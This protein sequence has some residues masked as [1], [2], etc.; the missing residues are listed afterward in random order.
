MGLDPRKKPC[1]CADSAT[2]PGATAGAAR[3]ATGGP[4]LPVTRAAGPEAGGPILLTCDGVEV[5]QAIQDMP[6]SVALVAEKRTIARV[7]LSTGG[8]APV[9]VNGVLRVR[10]VG[11]IGLG[12]AVRALAPVTLDPALT[13]NLRAK[14]ENETRSLNFILPRQVLKAGQWEVRLSSLF[15]PVPHKVIAVPAGAKRTVTFVASP[16]L[17]VRI[18]GIRYRSG[19]QTV[20]P[21]ALDFTLIQSWLGRAYPVASVDW[22]QVT[23]DG[24]DPWPFDAPAMNAFVRGLRAIDVAGGVDGRTHYYGLVADNGGSNFMR[25]LASGI[26]AT[27]DP[28]TVASGPCGGSDFGWDHDGSYGDWYTGHELGHTFGR[29]HAEF[30]GAGGGAAYPFP[31]GQLSGPDGAFVGFDVGDIGN[32]LPPRALPGTTSHDLMS[33]CDNQWVSSFTYGGI[34]TRLVAEEGLAGAPLRARGRGTAA[35]RTSARGG[36]MPAGGT[37]HVVATLNATQGTG[38]LRHVTPI[39]ASA[40]GQAP[41]AKGGARGATRGAGG[42]DARLRVFGAGDK[43]LGEYPAPWIQDSCRDEGDDDTGSI[44]VFVPGASSATK[45]ELVFNGAVVD[46]FTPAPT[47]KAVSNIRSSAPTRGARTRG[48]AARTAGGPGAADEDDDGDPVLTWTPAAAPAT[49]GSRRSRGATRGG[50]A[51]AAEAPGADTQYTVQ[52]SVDGGTTWQ[53]VGYALKEPTVR[54]DRTVLGDAATVKVRITA[55]SGFKSVTTEKTMK[56]S[57][58]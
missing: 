13:G 9:T 8:T 7:Y 34:R 33:Y 12:T 31:N 22:S 38:Q 1:G 28:T 39:A 58:L 57:D 5:T 49:R 14:R 25:G 54:I 6:H 30:C 44:D 3:G 19:T 2:T 55:T 50:P 42:H 56:A 43:L 23:V 32:G 29:F 17:R 15:R 37:I 21:G 27:A 16:P 26:P 36:A 18:I 40:A 46:T 10:K 24:P 41:L 35:R 48:G 51:A 47:P 45:L 11:S 52:V 4:R 20:A 53:T